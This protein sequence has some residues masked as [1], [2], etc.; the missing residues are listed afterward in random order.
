MIKFGGSFEYVPGERLGEALEREL[1]GVVKDVGTIEE[2]RQ[3][4]HD[5]MKRDNLLEEK[6]AMEEVKER[7]TQ[8]P[9]NPQQPFINSVQKELVYLLDLEENTKLKFYTAVSNTENKTMLDRDFGIDAFF[10]LE[11]EEGEPVTVPIDVTLKQFKSSPK[12]MILSFPDDF[13]SHARFDERGMIAGL[14]DSDY[15]TF[16]K[17]AEDVAQQIA[18]KIKKSLK[19]QS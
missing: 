2:E 4:V 18:G 13:P 19:T 3:K 10:E 7:Q 5:R 16:Q 15:N 12:V 11:Q 17:Y 9:E 6:A 8:N 1:L 14:S